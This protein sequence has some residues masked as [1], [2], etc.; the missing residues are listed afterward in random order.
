MSGQHVEHADKV[1]E[2]DSGIGKLPSS[3]ITYE[4]VVYPQHVGV[5]MLYVYGYTTVV[6]RT[7]G[8]V[9]DDMAVKRTET[10]NK[11]IARVVSQD[12]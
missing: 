8:G 1:L 5:S 2:K 11:S 10:C 6:G 9:E 4:H 12:V 7:G 3:S